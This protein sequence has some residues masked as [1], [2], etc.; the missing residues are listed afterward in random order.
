MLHADRQTDMTTLTV[1]YRN[2]ANAPKNL[3][4]DFI[5]NESIY[6][7]H[8]ENKFEEPTRNNP[9]FLMSATVYLHR[10]VRTNVP[11]K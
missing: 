4:S 5:L 8:W 2:F 3:S 9:P 7:P 10:I 1:A 6:S 11:S